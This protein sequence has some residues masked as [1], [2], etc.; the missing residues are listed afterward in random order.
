MASLTG[1]GRRGGLLLPILCTFAALVALYFVVRTAAVELAPAWAAGLPPVGDMDELREEARLAS[2]P[3]FK[4]KPELLDLARQAAPDEPL[5]FLPFYVFARAAESERDLPRAIALLEE[6]R[7]R[8]ATW[9]PIR[10]LLVASYVRQSRPREVVREIDYAL[11]MSEQARIVFLPELV[12][13]LRY[14]EGRRYVVE[15]LASDPPWEEDFFTVARDRKVPPEV[16]SELLRMATARG[17]D[18]REEQRLYVSS[19]VA[20]GRA[21]VARGRWLETLSPDQRQQSRFLHNGDFR[22]SA[23]VASFGWEFAAVDVGRADIIAGGDQS[24]LRAQY[25]GGSPATLAIQQIAL[26]PGRYRFQVTGRAATGLGA[27]QM[28][29]VIDCQSNGAKL[30]K[31]S[32]GG[33]QQQEKTIAADFTVPAGRCPAQRIYLVGEPGDVAARTEAEFRKVEIL[34]AR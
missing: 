6:A 1:S 2:H 21:D 12:K 13:L 18:T 29:W 24:L 8:R 17:G 33:L 26:P 11:R 27:A 31:L 3:E 10:L 23:P 19:L 34:D 9:L 25:Y 7:R 22:S 16:A 32:G 20:A 28:A 4:V 5:H 14:P 30:I 15:M